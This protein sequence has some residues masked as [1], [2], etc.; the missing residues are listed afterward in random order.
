M[1]KI[2]P[3]S[4]KLNDRNDVDKNRAPNETTLASSFLA[5]RHSILGKVQRRSTQMISGLAGKPYKKCMSMLKLTTLETCN[6]L[7]D[8]LEVFKEVFKMLVW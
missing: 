2:E 1:M 5:S 4:Q 7:A 8:P 3:C 6:I